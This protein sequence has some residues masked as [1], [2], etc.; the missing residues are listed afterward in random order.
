MTTERVRYA[1]R[2]AVLRDGGNFSNR[3]LSDGAVGCKIISEII[4]EVISGEASLARAC[5]D[6]NINMIKTRRV[7]AAL[8]NLKN[9][10]EVV[11]SHKKHDRSSCELF[12]CDIFDCEPN[13]TD[14]EDFLPP[15]PIDTLKTFLEKYSG[16]LLDDKEKTVIKERCINGKTL[17]D[18][19]KTMH[20]SK[21]RV[22][23]IYNK[24]TFKIRRSPS[25]FYLKLES[26]DCKTAEA[27]Y[28]L[29][30][31]EV[32]NSITEE[33]LRLDADVR[34]AEERLA[35]SREEFKKAYRDDTSIKDLGLSARSYNALRRAGIMTKADIVNLDMCE[36]ME[37]RSIGKASAKEIMAVKQK[38]VPAYCQ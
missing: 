33:Q 6:R 5:H 28:L 3:N 1:A 17:E 8:V 14:V 13:T 2:S 35:A 20:L 4:S 9:G 15:D 36:L 16:D 38:L 32:L 34:E 19:G 37:I 12:Y 24:A 10:E 31:N 26:A 29:R 27:V 30:K 21:E 25:K 18:I 7:I 23:Q 11:P 22:R